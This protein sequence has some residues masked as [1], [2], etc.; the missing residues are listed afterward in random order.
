MKIPAHIIQIFV[1]VQF[2]KILKIEINEVEL[3]IKY[4][5]YEQLYR[6]KLILLLQDFKRSL[7][8]IKAQ[9]K[10]TSE[11]IIK[12]KRELI[13]PF[14]LNFHV[15]NKSYSYTVVKLVFIFTTRQKIRGKKKKKKK[16]K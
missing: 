10:L 14:F 7:F 2:F 13:F 12:R 4:S 3:I 16:K 9:F 5:N 15:N 1:V 11:S 8:I 6:K